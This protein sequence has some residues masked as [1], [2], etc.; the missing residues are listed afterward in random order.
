MDVTKVASTR[1]IYEEEAQEDP[2]VEERSRIAKLRVT[3]E[4]VSGRVSQHLPLSYRFL[5]LRTFWNSLVNTELG[6][7]S[8]TEQGQQT[9]REMLPTLQINRLRLPPL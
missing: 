5:R 3:E 1:L 6:F 9:D 8:S 7:S 2:A 4:A